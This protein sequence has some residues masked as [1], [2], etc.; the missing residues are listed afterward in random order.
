MLMSLVKQR[1]S[2]GK[3]VEA[4]LNFWFLLNIFL[5]H[6]SSP[7]KEGSYIHGFY[8][9]GARWNNEL[10]SIG[11]SRLK[12]LFSKFPVVYVKATTQDKQDLRNIYECPVYRT[13]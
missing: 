12:E 10:N 8:M 1:T 11:P 3:H 5:K 7:P 6:F 2:L 4:S 13:R 9:E